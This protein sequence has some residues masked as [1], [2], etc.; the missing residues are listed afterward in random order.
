MDEALE[1]L[2]NVEPGDCI[3]CFNKQVNQSFV[4]YQIFIQMNFL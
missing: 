2:S 3:V 4:N 1:S